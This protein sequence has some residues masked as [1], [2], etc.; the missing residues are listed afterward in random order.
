[1]IHRWDQ[2]PL[3][4]EAGLSVYSFYYCS[5]Q[6][7][8]ETTFR[9]CWTEIW[10]RTSPGSSIPMT[11]WVIPLAFS[12]ETQAAYFGSACSVDLVKGFNI[13]VM[14]SVQNNLHQN[15]LDFPS[16]PSKENKCVHCVKPELVF[17]PWSG[18]PCLIGSSVEGFQNR[19]AYKRLVEALLAF[20]TEISTTSESL[21]VSCLASSPNLGALPALWPQWRGH[22][23]RSWP[24]SK[25][26]FM[27]FIHLFKLFPNFIL[28]T[29]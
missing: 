1:M 12:V 26:L 2:G 29:A 11:M 20:Q 13:D 22:G 15:C 8:L 17:C 27:Q 3:I 4:I 23:P 5:T 19:P 9:P 7:T 28:R 6:L 16:H 25:H 10:P 24:R 18:T 14:S 21:E